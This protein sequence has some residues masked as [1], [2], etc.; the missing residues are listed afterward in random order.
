MRIFNDDLTWTNTA[1]TADRTT[2][3]VWLGHI[4]TYAIQIVVSGGTSPTGSFILQ[5]SNDN[6]EVPGNVVNWATV[7]NATIAITDNGTVF[8]N[9][10]DAG[11]KWVRVFYDFT[12]GTG[13][14]SYSRINGKGV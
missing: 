7:P 4:I 13:T 11:Y 12:S 6:T 5:G 14:A 9:V 2:T 1:M 8:F 10:T 3:A